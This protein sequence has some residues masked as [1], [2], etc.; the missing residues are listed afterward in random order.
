MSDNL[1]LLS[2]LRKYFK[3]DTVSLYYHGDFDDVITDKIIT[4][5]S[6]EGKKKIRGNLAF[7]IAESFQNI[8]RHKNNALGSGNENVFGI[9]GRRDFIHVFSSN[10][11]TS[12]V[13]DDLQKRI[14]KINSMDKV[15]LKQ[16]YL[17]ILETGELNAK[18][19]AGMGLIE[20]SRR[21]GNQ[22][23]FEFIPKDHGAI[24]F[25]LQVDFNRQKAEEPTTENLYIEENSIVNELIIGHQILYI[26]KGSFNEDIMASFLPI[27]ESC[28]KS[29][30]DVPKKVYK[31]SIGLIQNLRHYGEIDKEGRQ[32]GLFALIKISG[33]FFVC[34]GNYTTEN[35]DE[36]TQIFEDLNTSSPEQLD[37]IYEKAR[38]NDQISDDRIGLLEIR[39]SCA[40]SF[41]LK[42]SEDAKGKYIMMGA[43]IK[44]Q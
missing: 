35:T 15:E 36:L 40:E 32:R 21:S 28:S 2:Q 29:R 39:R 44:D 1:K 31:T 26:Y 23:Q 41:E 37:E 22:L 5:M 30:A 14:E 3:G 7:T 6:Y 19:G 33:G 9:R 12:V 13:Q 25:N 27:L 24:T 17:Q 42:L 8:V 4:L 10:L 38:A 43:I 18:G 20:M 34:S 16:A 11:I